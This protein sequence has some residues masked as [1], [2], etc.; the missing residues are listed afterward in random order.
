MLWVLFVLCALWVLWL[1]WLLWAFTGV[2]EAV[3]WVFWVLW[4]LWAFAG[5]GLEAVLA[6]APLLTVFAGALF[7]VGAGELFAPA[8]QGVGAG[9]EWESIV[10]CI[11][12]FA[13]M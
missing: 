13:K 7:A 12:A 11:V 8:E 9:V 2:L 10:F 3:L 6:A 5:L 1:L 4:V